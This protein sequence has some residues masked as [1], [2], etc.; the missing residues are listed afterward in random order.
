MFR[1]RLSRSCVH[2]SSLG[3][4]SIA[5]IGSQETRRGYIKNFS[6]LGTSERTK[7]AT[8]IKFIKGTQDIDWQEEIKNVKLW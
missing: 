5:L 6:I 2:P 4:T 3:F 7:Q 8:S 1:K